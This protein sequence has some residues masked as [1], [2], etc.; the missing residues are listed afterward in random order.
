MRWFYILPILG[1]CLG[2]WM[3]VEVLVSAQSAP[4]QAAGAAMACACAI[5]PYVFARGMVELGEG[6]PRTTQDAT[7]QLQAES[8][9]SDSQ[10]SAKRKRTLLLGAAIVVAAVLAVA[11]YEVTVGRP[12]PE[13]A[14]PSFSDQFPSAR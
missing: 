4:Q 6:A 5:L 7:H 8:I 9:T 1:A 11:V 14:L 13:P 12:A 3:F 10:A 2:G